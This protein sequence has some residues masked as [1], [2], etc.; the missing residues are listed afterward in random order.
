MRC[1]K[2]GVLQDYHNITRRSCRVHFNN[3]NLI[4]HNCSACS[5]CDSLDSL[6]NCYHE[7]VY[8]YSFWWIVRRSNSV[9]KNK[10]ET[11][12]PHNNDEYVIL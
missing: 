1:L 3:N 4:K 7:W 11:K 2:C 9:I 8:F 12:I 5:R 10:F 6:D